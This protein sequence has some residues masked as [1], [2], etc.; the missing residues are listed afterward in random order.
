[1]DIYQLDHILH[2][3]EES[4]GW[5]YLAEVPTLSQSRQTLKSPG[6]GNADAQGHREKH[7]H[8]HQTLKYMETNK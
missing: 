2:E 8:T 3:P 7:S 5:I 4:E 1:M 6:A